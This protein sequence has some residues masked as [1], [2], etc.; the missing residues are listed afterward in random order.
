MSKDLYVA[1]AHAPGQELDG[2]LLLSFTIRESKFPLDVLSA[3]RLDSSAPFTEKKKHFKHDQSCLRRRY[4]MKHGL[5]ILLRKRNRRILKPVCLF[6]ASAA[7]R[8]NGYQRR[9]H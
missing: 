7:E 2:L 9:C 1:V 8:F 6:I 4:K 3:A 5:S